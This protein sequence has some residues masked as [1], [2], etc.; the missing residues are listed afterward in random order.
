MLDVAFLAGFAYRLSKHYRNSHRAA[1]LR[2]IQ[3]QSKYL[4]RCYHARRHLQR[5]RAA[6]GE[7]CVLHPPAVPGKDS[8]PRC[9][10]AIFI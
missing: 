7:E 9:H 2:S 4:K 5:W 8:E 3:I 10:F 1:A 6:L